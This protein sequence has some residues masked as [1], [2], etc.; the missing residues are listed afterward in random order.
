MRVYLPSTLPALR[1][2]LEERQVT[3]TA[4]G[5]VAYAVTSALRDEHAGADLEEL[6]YEAL[7]QAARESVRLLAAD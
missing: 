5:T 1:R 7:T 4:R 2:L 3:S 6:E